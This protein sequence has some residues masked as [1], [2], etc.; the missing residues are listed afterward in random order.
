MKRL[1]IAALLGLAP[2]APGQGEPPLITVRVASGLSR[3]IFV[4]APPGDTARLFIVEQRGSRGVEDRA[5]VRILRLTDGVL[6]PQPFMALGGL[7]TGGEQGLLGLAFHPQYAANRQFY[8][9][10]T[11]AS[12]RTVVKRFRASTTNPNAVEAG[13]GRVILTIPQPQ[14]NHNGGWL[15][16]GPDGF[17]YIATGDGGGGG[18]V[19][20]GH[21]PTIGNGQFLG[22]L[23][24]KMLRI[25]VDNP[26]P[27]LAYSVPPSNPF[28]A[29]PTWARKEI[30]AYGLRNP[31]R[32]AFDRATGE[33]YIADVGQGDWEE[34]NVQAAGDGGSNYGWRCYEGDAAFNTANCV[35]QATMTFP[36]H[37]YSHTDGC[38]ITGGYVYRGQDI[39]ELRGTYFFADFCTSTIWSLRYGGS[40]NPVTADRTAELAPLD[41]LAIGNVLSFGE[42]GRGELYIADLDGQVFRIV[43]RAPAMTALR[44]PGAQGNAR[45]GLS[46]AGVRDASGDARGDAAIGSPLEDLPGF[47]DCG[48]VDLFSGANGSLLRTI[49]PPNKQPGGQFGYSVAGLDNINGDALGDVLVG[50]PREN[51]GATP[52]D[53]GR[54]YIFRGDT[55]AMVR[56]IKSP[57]ERAGGFFGWAACAVPDLNGDGRTEYMISAPAEAVGGRFGAGRVYLFS[58]ANGALLRTLWSPVFEVNGHFGWSVASVPDATGDGKADLLIGAPNDDP[59]ASPTD[60][61]RVYLYSGATFALV[62]VF[63]SP[64]PEAG[65]NFGFSVAGVPSVNGDAL[66]DIVIGAPGDNPGSSP[67]DAGRAYMY[68]GSGVYIRTLAPP[69]PQAGAEFGAAVAGLSDVTGD[70]RGDVAVASPRETVLGQADAGR[71]Y[72][73]SGATGLMHLRIEPPGTD[74]GGRFGWALGA[75]PDASNNNRAELLVGVPLAHIGP[76]PLGAGAAFIVQN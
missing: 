64:F 65:G 11:D 55:G 15:S 25:D 52:V 49:N 73:F 27:P 26:A 2:A 75:V 22:T 31:W 45:F 38:S 34:I 20:T 37:T 18:D 16:F 46:A 51:P 3:P 32:N 28:F 19:G 68:S 71:V 12:G 58:G 56:A 57:N 60:C 40:P 36:I 13:S 66:G 5:E 21:H 47:A 69:N 33:L 29:S 35:S 17:L 9:N 76:V 24:G 67:D 54:A 70:A 14:D 30:W 44:P 62:R 8:V 48:R 72:L 50:A 41:G 63:G 6:I 1:A 39:P 61:G 7:S 10:F 42:D 59:G 23:L 43:Q 53:A 74:A 4:T